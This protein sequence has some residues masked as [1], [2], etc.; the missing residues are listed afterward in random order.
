MKE[1]KK[2]KIARQER[3]RIA[4]MLSRPG[5]LRVVYGKPMVLTDWDDQGKYFVSIPDWL[6]DDMHLGRWVENDPNKSSN[7]SRE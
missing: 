3:E 5:L 1:K 4:K 7:R 6:R 2:L